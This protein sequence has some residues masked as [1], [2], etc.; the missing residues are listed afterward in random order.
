ME[1]L[2]PPN[3]DKSVVDGFGDEWS[4]FDQ[5]KLSHE[6]QMLIFNQYFAIFPWDLLAKDA[7]GF[8][9]GCGSGRWAEI[10]A[11]RVGTLNVIDASSEAMNVARVKLSNDKNV[12]FFVASVEEIP[13][14]DGSQDFGYSL[15]VL[16]HIPDTQAALEACVKKIK[17]GAPF[18]V[19]LYYRFDNK[20]FWFRAIWSASDIFRR[21]I[22]RL[23]HSGRY[24]ASQLLAGFIYWP[25]AKLSQLVSGLGFGVDGIP[26]SSYRDKSF[27]TMR[28]DALDRFGTRLEQR[29]T[30]VE[31][32]EMMLKAGL[33]DIKFN[34]SVPYW[35][36]VGLRTR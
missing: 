11:K 7:S 15:G 20:P 19:Y 17:M 35:C 10:V 3:I 33:S 27:Y 21:V 6:E 23:P 31:I 12:N 9:M 25:L 30:R 5:S 2:K 1:Q 26:L 29:F 22:S 28:T 4:R 16:H 18:L 36:A 32:S 34:S 14:A 8:D 24:L 13:L